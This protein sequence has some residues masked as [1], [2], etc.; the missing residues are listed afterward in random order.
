MKRR[1][2]LVRLSRAA[3][4]ELESEASSGERLSDEPGAPAG[5]SPVDAEDIAKIYSPSLR[6]LAVEPAA[7]AAAAAGGE[8]GRAHV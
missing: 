5:G 2:E 4:A 1:N 6:R 8:I 7:A 3:E